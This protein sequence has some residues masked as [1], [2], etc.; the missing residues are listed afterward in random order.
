MHTV[1]WRKAYRCQDAH[2]SN[3]YVRRI[4]KSHVDCER[5]RQNQIEAQTK[6]KTQPRSHNLKTRALT[7]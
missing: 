5:K 2:I 1:N 6:T 7:K 4:R 3:A